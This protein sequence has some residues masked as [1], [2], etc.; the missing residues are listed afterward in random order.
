MSIGRCILNEEGPTLERASPSNL[1]LMLDRL[2]I[3]QA[4]SNTHPT[5]LYKS[6]TASVT[7]NGRLT[8]AFPVLEAA[9]VGVRC[10]RHDEANRETS[11]QIVPDPA[12]SV[13]QVAARHLNS[14]GSLA[15]TRTHHSASL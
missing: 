5:C 2:N 7:W 10:Q 15:A 11:T 3:R 6:S 1:M 12:G 14:L 8:A 4:K 9:T 13:R